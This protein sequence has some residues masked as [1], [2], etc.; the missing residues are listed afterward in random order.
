M[1]FIIVDEGNVVSAGITFL[2][3][4][5][6]NQTI[7]GVFLEP[8]KMNL[9]TNGTQKGR[10]M[11]CYGVKNM[12]RGVKLVSGERG[13]A[14]IVSPCVVAALYAVLRVPVPAAAFPFPA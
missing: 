7:D 12:G 14:V 9:L 3:E 4:M 13:I 10:K 2:P 5:A 8:L 11:A 1:P 6:G